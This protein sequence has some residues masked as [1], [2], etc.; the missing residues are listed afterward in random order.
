MFVGMTASAQEATWVPKNLAVGVGV[1]TTG[2]VIDA[3]TTIH[4]YLGVRFGVDIFPKIKVNKDI[5]LKTESANKQLSQLTS[6]INDLNTKL[7]AAE[8]GWLWGTDPIPL[9][10]KGPKPHSCSY[11]YD[12]REI[13]GVHWH[14]P[15]QC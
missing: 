3:S 8:G 11:R 13:Q 7:I 12:T 1:G 9:G 6:E 4:N 5:N 10:A 14:S 15:G 2:I